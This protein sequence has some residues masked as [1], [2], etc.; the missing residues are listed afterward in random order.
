MIEQ[1][2]Y[3]LWSNKHFIWWARDSRGY[4][5]DIHDAGRYTEAA[6]RQIEAASRSRGA[7]FTVVRNNI[8]DS[9]EPKGHD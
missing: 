2:M 1:P 8:L 9:P 6:A 4:T 3:L 5:T 7:A